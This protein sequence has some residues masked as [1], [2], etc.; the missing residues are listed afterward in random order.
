MCVC[1]CV[2][3]CV[4]Q[5]SEA[6]TEDVMMKRNNIRFLQKKRL[7]SASLSVLYFSVRDTFYNVVQL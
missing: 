2:C 4:V 5:L 7:H 1:V 3:V 6:V